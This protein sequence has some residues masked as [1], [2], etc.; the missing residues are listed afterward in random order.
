MLENSTVIAAIPGTRNDT[1]SAPAR[2]G[3]LDRRAQAEAERDQPQ[4]RPHHAGDQ[5]CAGRAGT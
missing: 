3:Q 5:G 4:E 1:K 2:A